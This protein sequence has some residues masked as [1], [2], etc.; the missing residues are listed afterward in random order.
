MA[1]MKSEILIQRGRAAGYW[2]HRQTRFFLKMMLQFML[3]LSI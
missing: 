3:I 2:L 1:D